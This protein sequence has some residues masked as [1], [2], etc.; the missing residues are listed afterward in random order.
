MYKHKVY[1]CCGWCWW[2]GG[3]DPQI[4]QIF[5]AV[6]PFYDIFIVNKVK[7]FRHLEANLATSMALSATK[8]FACTCK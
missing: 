4:W 7:Y 6:K 2:G 1:F 5:N 3:G 8:D